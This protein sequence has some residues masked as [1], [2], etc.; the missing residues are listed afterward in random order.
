MT[1]SSRPGFTLVEVLVTIGIVGILTAIAL[2]AVQSARESARQT[3][4]ANRVRQLILGVHLHEGSHRS[5]PHNGGLDR[6]RLPVL[7]PSLGESPSTLEYSSGSLYAWGVGSPDLSP[8]N[9]AGSW[10]YATLPY[11]EDRAA[12]E[13]VETS[14]RPPVV[15]CPS[16][17]GREPSMVVN[18]AHGR[19]EGGDLVWSKT[20]YAGNGNAIKR[21]P[22]LGS[23][24]EFT[25]GLSN[26]ILV[27]EKMFNPN[28]QVDSSWLFDES[29][30]LGGSLGTVRRSKLLLTDGEHENFKT[31][32]GSQHYGKVGFGLADGSHRWI[33]NQ[34]DKL[35]LQRL[36][37]L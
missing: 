33:S 6:G 8:T 28:I 4:C 16:R 10:L 31:S 26:T 32:W 36:M 1:T 24:S 15:I 18:D 37:E 34:T 22:D 30:Y 11:L 5:I 23:F 12:Y 29:F 19:Y 14:H 3:Q 25:G 9:Q 7:P 21:L 13:A 27:G 20:D 35:V 2:P 17:I